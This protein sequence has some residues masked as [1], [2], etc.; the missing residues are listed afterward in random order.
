MSLYEL[1]GWVALIL[2]VW[3][4][5]ALAKKSTP[6]WIIRLVCNFAWIGYSIPFQ[7][8]PLLANHITFGFIN[9]YGWL[10]WRKTMYRCKCGRHYDLTR[11]RGNCICEMPIPAW[12][13]VSTR[14]TRG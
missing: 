11:D 8:W 12:K 3:G 14:A 6:G 9:V 4:N 13:L 10:E 5:L 7:T 1:L 2:N